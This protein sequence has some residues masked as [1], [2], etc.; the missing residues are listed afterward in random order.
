MSS[1]TRTHDHPP[2][3]REGELATFGAVHLDVIDLDRSLGFWRDLIG[4]QLQGRARDEAS[5]GTDEDT[6]L[7]LHAEATSPVRRGHA[8][9]YHLAIHLPNE[10]EFARLSEADVFAR[11]LQSMMQQSPDLKAALGGAESAILGHVREGADTAH[12]VVRAR[13]STQGVAIAQVS[14]IS[15]RR[16]GSGW[17]VLLSGNFD[18]VAAARGRRGGT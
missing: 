18:G 11:F 10:A 6:L 7:V 3:N 14:V 5:L 2:A 15:M 13:V 16:L 17:G 12:A 1:T 9:L 4:L 8:G